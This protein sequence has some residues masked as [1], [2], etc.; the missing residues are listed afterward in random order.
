MRYD[1]IDLEPGR[2][3]DGVVPR[4]SRLGRSRVSLLNRTVARVLLLGMVA[5]LWL[6]HLDSAPDIVP[7]RLARGGPGVETLAFAFSPD[8]QTIATT[9]SDGR[10]ALR[11]VASGW[12][13][14]RFLNDRGHDWAV[15]FSPDGRTL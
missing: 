2:G 8:G 15:A 12:S 4:R 9:Q 5:L 7:T 6:S 3:Y 14:L 11:E 13:I 10:V 1:A